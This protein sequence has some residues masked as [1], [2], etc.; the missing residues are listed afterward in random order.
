MAACKYVVV[1]ATTLCTVRPHIRRTAD[2]EVQVD[3]TEGRKREVTLVEDELRFPCVYDVGL[4]LRSVPDSDEVLPP[5]ANGDGDNKLANFVSV[6]E[7]NTRTMSSLHSMQPLTKTTK[8]AL[9]DSRSAKDEAR[10]NIDDEEEEEAHIPAEAYL[11]LDVSQD[12]AEQ[13]VVQ[14]PRVYKKGTACGFSDKLWH[15]KPACPTRSG[16]MVHVKAAR[17]HF[18]VGHRFA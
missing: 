6:S 4:G 11:D 17:Q 9:A 2:G 18:M 5:F 10:T 16:K 12:V 15:P 8:A 14:E 7:D 3:C 13:I 1:P